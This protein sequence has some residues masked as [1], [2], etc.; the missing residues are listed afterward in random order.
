M[1]LLDILQKELKEFPEGMLYAVQDGDG[2]AIS[3]SKD[4]YRTPM[5]DAARLWPRFPSFVGARPRKSAASP[6]RGLMWIYLIPS[7]P[8]P[9]Y[10]KPI[11]RQPKSL[12]HFR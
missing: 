12:C 3:I 1:K 11:S 5:W 10:R 6:Q 2:E 4:L 8:N 9:I 7:I